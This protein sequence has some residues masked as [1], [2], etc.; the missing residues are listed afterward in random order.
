MRIGPLFNRTTCD[1]HF[2]L[3]TVRFLSPVVN[4]TLTLAENKSGSDN[5]TTGE[6]GRVI[7]LLPVICFR[8]NVRFFFNSNPVVFFKEWQRSGTSLWSKETV[9]FGQ[10]PVASVTCVLLRFIKSQF[11]VSF[12][13]YEIVKATFVYL[14]SKLKS[15]E[16][17]QT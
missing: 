14:L 15:G 10:V 12:D 16:R 5:E 17:F 7:C 9:K 6:Q 13:G 4:F 1:N 3:F 8:G 2:Y 11:S